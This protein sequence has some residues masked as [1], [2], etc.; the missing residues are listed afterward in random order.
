MKT[1]PIFSRVLDLMPMTDEESLEE[2]NFT[3]LVRFYEEE[4]KKILIGVSVEES[5]TIFERR[6][7][8]RLGILVYRN[9]TWTLSERAIETIQ[10]RI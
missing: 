7:L 9:K 6:K 4:L 5:F 10:E 2:Q 3:N 1:T 8:R